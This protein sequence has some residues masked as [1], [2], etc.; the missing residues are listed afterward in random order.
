[1]TDRHPTILS[2]ELVRVSVS[3]DTAHVTLDD[4]SNRNAASRRM[5]H[6]LSAVLAQIARTNLRFV[7]LR[8]EGGVFSS[9]GDLK[10]L[11]G[12]LPDDY[13]TDYWQRMS[14]SILAMRSMPQIIIG[15]VEGA[16]VGAGAA[17][18]LAC[19][20][21]VAEENSRMRFTFTRI[22]LLPDAGTTMILPHLLGGAVA[23]DLL[24]TGRWIGAKEACER[25]LIAR[26]CPVG[27]LTQSVDDLLR[28]L[29][30]SPPGALS[31]AKNLVE[32]NALSDLTAAVRAEGVQQYAAA[33]SGEYREYLV[34]VLARMASNVPTN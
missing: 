12:G 6:E 30:Y 13:V 1:M 5:Y 7:V 10:E 24:L 2:T 22:G 16:A 32:A 8:G 23:R 9:G 33:A 26:V 21:V 19:D 34:R 27:T 25:G 31:M 20:V 18:A 4:P 28:E 17:I 29:Q 11:S 14:G 15:A 3:G